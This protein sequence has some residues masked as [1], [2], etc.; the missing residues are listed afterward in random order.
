MGAGLV[1]SIMLL[2]GIVVSLK[3]K[4]GTLVVT[5]S[6]T[7]ADVQVLNEQEQIEVTRKGD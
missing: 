3:T 6:E 5:V 2:A 1:A 4:E 7:D